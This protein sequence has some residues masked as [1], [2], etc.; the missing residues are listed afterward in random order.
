MVPDLEWEVP[1]L[2]TLSTLY[3]KDVRSMNGGIHLRR[4]RNTIKANAVARLHERPNNV[5]CQA[6]R[7]LLGCVPKDCYE[8]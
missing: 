3:C 1:S 5:H 4:M 2:V 8:L 7:E 6:A